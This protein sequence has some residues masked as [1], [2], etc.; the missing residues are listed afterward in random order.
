MNLLLTQVDGKKALINW[1]NVGAAQPYKSGSI[2]YIAGDDYAWKVVETLEEI[3]EML[4][5]HISKS[6]TT[7]QE[8]S[9]RDNPIVYDVTTFVGDKKRTCKRCRD[10]KKE[11]RKQKKSLQS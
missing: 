9:T 1:S 4:N 6:C 10:L 3:Q 2:I 8:P 5:P 11:M 7:C